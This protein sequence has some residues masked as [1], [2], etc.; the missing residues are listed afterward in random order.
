[1][2]GYVTLYTCVGE[3]EVGTTVRSTPTPTL[4]TCAGEQVV[5]NAVQSA[6]P[7][8]TPSLNKESVLRQASL[9]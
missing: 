1:M 3:E 7:T 9:Y 5:G 6:E 8:T 2:S 4:Y